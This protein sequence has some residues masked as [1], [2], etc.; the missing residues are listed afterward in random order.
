[1]PLASGQCGL[2]TG[3]TNQAGGETFSRFSGFQ[4]VH[5][6]P[7]VSGHPQFGTDPNVVI[8]VPQS[9]PFKMRGSVARAAP[10]GCSAG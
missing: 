7:V 4:T 5:Q 1:M 6:A 8:P 2:A 3:N 9:E 10:R